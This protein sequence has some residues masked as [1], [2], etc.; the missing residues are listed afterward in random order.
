LTEA[1]D[2]A[3]WAE[4]Q[5]ALGNAWLTREDGDQPTHLQTAITH[6]E[7]ALRIESLERAP[8]QWLHLNHMLASAYQELGHDDRAI[9]Y[10]RR[11]LQTPLEVH[12]WV[13]LKI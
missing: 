2:P 3:A 5:R 11:A 12:K 10:Y 6:F 13:W 7:Q 8:G 9:D 4:V 1:A